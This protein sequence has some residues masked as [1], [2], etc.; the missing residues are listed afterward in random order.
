[1]HTQ[2]APEVP[3]PPAREPPRGAPPDPGGEGG[4]PRLLPLP[5][6]VLVP[7]VVLAVYA[8][9][10]PAGDLRSQYQG[11]AVALVVAPLLGWLLTR[12]AAWAH[13]AAGALTAAVMP[14]LTLI[15]LHGTEWFL[16]G[17]F[18]DNSF[19]MEYAT[20]FADDLGSLSDYTY[21]GVPAFY[22]PGWFWIVGLCAR[23]TG[24]H[25]WQAYKWVAIA[26]LYLA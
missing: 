21:R 19:R 8:V 23:L 15:A 14:G 13:H 18:G 1:M 10:P 9:L 17:P 7:V 2:G 25:A 16:S 22:S 5:P 26:T 3:P 20:R 12:R 6:W 11:S 24:V 4:L